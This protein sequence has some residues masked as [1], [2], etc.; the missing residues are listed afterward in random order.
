M[1]LVSYYKVLE[2]KFFLAA[3]QQANE[4]QRVEQ[5]CRKAIRAQRNAPDSED[6][7]HDH[8]IGFGVGSEKESADEQE[9]EDVPNTV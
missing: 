9:D 6:E 7:H 2:Y 8:G 5:A 1:G 4:A 3:E